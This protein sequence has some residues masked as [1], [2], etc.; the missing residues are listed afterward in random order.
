[1]QYAAKKTLF[2]YAKETLFDPMGFSNEEWMHEDPA[3]FD[4]PAYGLR[5]RPV[6]M[7]KFG[8]LYLNQGCWNGQ[9]LLSKEWISTS[10]SPW[11]KSNP[12]RHD[13]NYGWYWWQDRFASGWIGHTANGWKGQRIT[14]FPRQAIVVTTTE[15]MEDGSEN[16]VYDT[17]I[18]RFIR[19]AIASNS[20]VPADV[21]VRT[22]L[23]SLLADVWANKNVITGTVEAR[24]VPTVTAKERHRAFMP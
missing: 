6:D 7:Q 23:Q 1:V 22:K 8:M 5:L 15:I 4:N 17:I 12:A 19:P 2:D 9:Q 3:G 10:F 11:I 13:T 16:M 18:N 14:V 20:A 24:M 21:A